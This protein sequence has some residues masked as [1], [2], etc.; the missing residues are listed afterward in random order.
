VTL[1]PSSPAQPDAGADISLLNALAYV[2]ERS[3]F[4]FCDPASRETLAAQADAHRAEA[5]GPATW[6]HASIHFHGCREGRMELALPASLARGLCL[7][8][9]GEDDPAAITDDALRDF[10]GEVA[11]MTCGLWLTRR[12][13]REP[14]DLMPPQ[15]MVWPGDASLERLNAPAQAAE[16]VIA[17]INDAAIWLRTEWLDGAV[18]PRSV[19]AHAIRS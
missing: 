15:V 6:L 11:N 3:L 1:S 4:A 16:V 2:A 5:G 7:A 14:F 18:A 8:F 13:R 10:A 19:H 12:S 17:T 9:S